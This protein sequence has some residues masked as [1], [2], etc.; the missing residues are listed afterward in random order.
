M[1]WFI[2]QICKT[3]SSQLHFLVKKSGKPIERSFDGE[4]VPSDTLEDPQKREAFS[5]P[6][7]VGRHSKE[8]RFPEV[9]A[10]A[11]ALKSRFP[12]VGAV[13]FCYGG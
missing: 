13:G 7:F 4:V 8:K 10:C 2:C 5:V 3:V 11:R 1:Q 12:K 6:A 9:L